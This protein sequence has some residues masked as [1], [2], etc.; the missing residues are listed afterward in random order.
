MDEMAG[1]VS[2]GPGAKPKPAPVT[3]K[4]MSFTS[5]LPNKALN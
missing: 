5:K 1:T 2:A 4:R 3:P